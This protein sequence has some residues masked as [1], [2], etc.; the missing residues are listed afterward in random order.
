MFDKL[1]A[2]TQAM[3]KV[4]EAAGAEAEAKV[5][6]HDG[7]SAT[8]VARWRRRSAAAYWGDRRQVAVTWRRWI[9]P[10]SGSKCRTPQPE[11]KAP[12]IGV[13]EHS[14][15][16]YERG[17]Y[18]RVVVVRFVYKD[19]STADGAATETTVEPTANADADADADG[20]AAETSFFP[21][22]GAAARL[23]DPQDE[24][25]CRGRHG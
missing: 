10:W 24:P 14:R 9:S 19:A 3:E 17:G 6:E 5:D 23:P 1:L 8:L 11:G 13:E 25:S 22:G 12:R 2:E 16:G 7:A 4:L 15:V 20:T 21:W 18:R